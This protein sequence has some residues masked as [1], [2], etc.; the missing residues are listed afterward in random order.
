M[1]ENNESPSVIEDGAWLSFACPHCHVWVTVHRPEVNCGIFRHGVF[2]ETGQPVP[3]H[4]S[5]PDC[6]QWHAT[7][8]IWGCGKP[9]RLSRGAGGVDD[10][11]RVDICD[12][13]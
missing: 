10:G 3:P 12:Y 13:I 11:F 8:Q 4:A 7:D 2:R 6:E 9:F 5:Q 1:Q